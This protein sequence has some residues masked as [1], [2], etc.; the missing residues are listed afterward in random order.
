MPAFCYVSRVAVPVCVRENWHFDA[1]YDVIYPQQQIGFN[2][3]I[4]F[5]ATCLFITSTS[6]THTHTFVRHSSLL[7]LEKAS[8]FSLENIQSVWGLLAMNK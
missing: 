5:M 6:V 7:P 2:W 3:L 8:P 1:L 4:V